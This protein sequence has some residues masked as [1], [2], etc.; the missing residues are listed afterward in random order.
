M[1]SPRWRDKQRRLLRRSALTARWW[2]PPGTGRGRSGSPTRGPEGSSGSGSDG[3]DRRGPADPSSVA[4]REPLL[5]LRGHTC[6]AGGRAFSPDGTRLAS[7]ACDG[8]RIW[9]DIDNLLDIAQRHALAHRRGV[10]PLPSPP[11]LPGRVG[12]ACGST[13]QGEVPR[14]STH[15][16]SVSPTTVPF[17][18]LSRH[19]RNRLRWIRRRHPSVSELE[20]L[21]A[22]SE[23]KA[24][25]Y[26][27]RGHRRGLITVGSMEIVLVVDE[28]TTR[29]AVGE[30]G[31]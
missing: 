12:R 9:L 4:L 24:L 8:I 10:S 22:V 14:S 23:G 11:W 29:R 7:R 30:E 3:L 21:H 6:R 27:D 2:R 28:E 17:V 1:G 13:S 25:G 18:R 31:A 20:L 16:A 19:A 15:V 5:I 26:D